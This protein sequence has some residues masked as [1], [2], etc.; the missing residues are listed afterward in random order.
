MTTVWKYKN[1]F[2]TLVTTNAGLWLFWHVMQ[3]WL[4]V[5]Y[6]HLGQPIGPIFKSQAA[7]EERFDR[8]TFELRTN[9]QRKCSIMKM[10]HQVSLNKSVR[11][12]NDIIKHAEFH[13]HPE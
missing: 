10:S 1:C 6:L 12:C 4:V 5:G 13:Y 9:I 3:S 7:Q 8:L 11:N 2:I